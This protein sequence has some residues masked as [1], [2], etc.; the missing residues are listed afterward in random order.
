MQSGNTLGS[1]LGVQ[2][3]QSQRQA[4]H[5]ERLLHAELCVDHL[6]NPPTPTEVGM[7]IMPLTE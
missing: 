4:A 2:G 5:I 1:S 3:S 6:I 7:T